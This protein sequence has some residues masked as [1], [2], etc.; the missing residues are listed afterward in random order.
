MSRDSIRSTIKCQFCGN[1]IEFIAYMAQSGN[2]LGS[3]HCSNCR[4]KWISHG[5]DADDVKASLERGGDVGSLFKYKEG[6][7]VVW[8][9]KRKD[10]EYMH[11]GIVLACLTPG[12]DP[13]EAMKLCDEGE[14]KDWQRRFRAWKKDGDE[15]LSH[16]KRYLVKE[17][18]A[19]GRVL[20]RK[21]VYYA[22]RA[23]AV[24]T[25]M[26]KLAQVNMVPQQ[27]RMNQ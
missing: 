9:A 23:S 8:V 10:K 12:T 25:H 11:G 13:D 2:W 17:V 15:C 3:V 7:Q 6:D 20:K 24:E 21:P 27:I 1:Q 26:E 14:V 22:P 5:K 4:Y 19:D 18:R 16:F